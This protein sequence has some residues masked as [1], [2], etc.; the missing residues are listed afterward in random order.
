MSEV[1]KI[2]QFLSGLITAIADFLK[3]IGARKS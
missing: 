3:R 1:S 2:S